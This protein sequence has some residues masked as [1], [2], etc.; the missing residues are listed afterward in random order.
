MMNV[1]LTVLRM[2]LTGSL[3]ILLVLLLRIGLKRAPK[4][5]SY[6][7]WAAVL[8]RLL[9]PF[10]IPV[11]IPAPAFPPLTTEKTVAESPVPADPD[12]PAPEPEP[13]LDLTSPPESSEALPQDP[14]PSSLPT[15]PTSALPDDHSDAALPASL[16][17]EEEGGSFSRDALLRVCCGIWLLGAAL[18]TGWN[19]AAF[20]SL[21]VRLREAVPLTEQDCGS[22]V[23]ETDRIDTAFV[24]GLIRPRIFLPAGLTP[25]ERSCVLEH[26]RTHIRRADPLWRLLSFAALAVHWFNPLVWLAFSLSGRDMEMSCDESLMKK[27]QADIRADYAKILV[28]LSSPGMRPNPALAFGEG[29][30][31]R[32]V[33]NVMRYKKPLLRVSVAAGIVLVLSAVVLAVNLT[34]RDAKVYHTVYSVKETAFLATEEDERTGEYLRSIRYSLTGDD[35]LYACDPDLVSWGLSGRTSDWI[36]D[37][38]LVSDIVRGI[39]S[40]EDLRG[41]IRETSGVNIGAIAEAKVGLNEPTSPNH[42][43]YMTLF[44]TRDGRI[45]YAFVGGRETFEKGNVLW[46]LELT[47]ED[48]LSSDG[49]VGFC[50]RSLRNPVRDQLPGE[51]NPEV[52]VWDFIRDREDRII[53]LFAAGDKVCS[54]VAKEDNEVPFHFGVAVFLPESGG[55]GLRLAAC[56]IC[57]GVTVTR[58]FRDPVPP[59]PDAPGT[60][61]RE[62]NDFVFMTED[63]K[64]IRAALTLPERKKTFFG[65]TEYAGECLIRYPGEQESAYEVPAFLDALPYTRY[66]V[67][68]VLYF[69]RDPAPEAIAQIENYRFEIAGDCSLW[70]NDWYETWSYVGKGSLNPSFEARSVP[71]WILEQTGVDVGNVKESRRFSGVVKSGWIL[72]ST[73]DGGFYAASVIPVSDSGFGECGTLCRLRC[74]VDPESRMWIDKEFVEHSLFSAALRDIYVCSLDVINPPGIA[75]VPFVT[76]LTWKEINTMASWDSYKIPHQV[77]AAVFELGARSARLVKW[78]IDEDHTFIG[79]LP[80]DVKTELPSSDTIRYTLPDGSVLRAELTLPER[81]TLFFGL[82]EQNQ[83]VGR[84]SIRFVTEQ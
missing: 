22:R 25:S 49:E 35:A 68:E 67:E 78:S 53:L 14:L 9:T 12:R 7:L 5:Y 2:S 75:V 15:D 80:E 58:Q 43:P 82:I 51:M 74:D 28:K 10:G 61:R 62:G 32:R 69:Y 76:G 17:A 39:G 13:G 19:A 66:M 84:C 64:T 6:L 71:E 73:T 56:K 1:F 20:F 33:K 65:K 29:D 54:L 77:G 70:I 44:S 3:V 41:M 40:A 31:G 47:P 42:S 38:E 45:W 48:P 24:A 55:K 60:V 59:E 46:L 11:S 83:L 37:G 50:T 81:K 18:I 36:E 79:F 52:F 8:F 72:L 27:A 23:F 57:P 26:E 63:G 16:S 21:G 30:T 34:T 4:I